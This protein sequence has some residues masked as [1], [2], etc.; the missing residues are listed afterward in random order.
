MAR[1]VW[2]RS[3]QLFAKARMRDMP[4]ARIEL[5]LNRSAVTAVAALAL[6][7]GLTASRPAQALDDDGSQNVF[8]AV[9]G[10]IDV[11]PNHDDAADE[12]DYRERAPLV[13]PPR[14][15]LPPPVEPGARR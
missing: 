9:L 4:M 11:L 12:I 6:A 7:A 3:S 10:L 1:H 15:D 14:M 2:V 8:T 13:L 5:Y